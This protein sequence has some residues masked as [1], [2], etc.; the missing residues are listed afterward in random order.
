MGVLA[1]QRQGID[2]FEVT[3]CAFGIVTCASDF[4]IAHAVADQQDHVFSGF[5]RQR[6]LQC[7]GLIACQTACTAGF[8]NIATS[9]AV[10]GLII[11]SEGG[12][13]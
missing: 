11:I 10:G 6:R 3:A 4:R 8:G 2:P 12:G 5:I 7:S 1:G 13:T 9:R